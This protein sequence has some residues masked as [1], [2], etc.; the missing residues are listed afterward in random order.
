[1]SKLDT[2]SEVK[3][4]VMKS[5]ASLSKLIPAQAKGDVKPEVILDQIH[6]QLKHSKNKDKLAACKAS[7]IAAAIKYC[8]QMGLEPGWGN[9]TP[10]VYLIVYGTDCTTQLSYAGELK[11][12]KR[13]GKF[14]NLYSDIVYSGDEFTAWNDM[15]GQHFEHKKKGF[16][17]R[18]D[19]NIVGVYAAALTNEGDPYLEIMTVEQVD[20]LE[21]KTRKGSNQ[22]PAWRDW[23]TQMA[24]KTV[25]RRV[26]KN[27]PQ[28]RTQTLAESLDNQSTVLDVE[29]EKVSTN[30]K[31]L[32]SAKDVIG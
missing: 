23:W 6:H 2:Y 27:L 9:G 25:L 29:P 24:R 8:C 22:S 21:K 18:T 30:V 20:Q 4:L 1:M 5:H 7:T 26:I 28:S 31:Q 12:A 19:E 14:K 16:E 15:E 3:A 17:N 10:D 11:L 13:E 32:T